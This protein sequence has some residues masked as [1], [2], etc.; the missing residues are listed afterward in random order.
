MSNP[1]PRQLAI[2]SVR[3]RKGLLSRP[4]LRTTRSVLL[5][6]G[7]SFCDRL[8]AGLALRRFSLISSSAEPPQEW[9]SR[10]GRTDPDPG[11]HRLHAIVSGD[12]RVEVEL[13]DLG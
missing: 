7:T 13:G 3:R 1:A 2:L 9:I 11:G 12:D 5:I 6:P 10:P 8:L 4:S